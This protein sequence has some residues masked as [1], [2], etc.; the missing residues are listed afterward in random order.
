MNKFNYLGYGHNEW[1]IK[2]QEVRQ[3]FMRRYLPCPYKKPKAIPS[4]IAA[5][6]IEGDGVQAQ[7]VFDRLGR[8]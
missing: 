7:V 4:Y 3:L 5:A 2:L 1:S 8:R 6:Y